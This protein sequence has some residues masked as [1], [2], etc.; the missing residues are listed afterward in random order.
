[1]IEDFFLQ[2]FG[3]DFDMQKIGVLEGIIYESETYFK[4]SK[5]GAYSSMYCKMAWNE[6][7][8]TNDADMLVFDILYRIDVENG[9]DTTKILDSTCFNGAFGAVKVTI[10]SL[11]EGNLSYNLSVCVYFHTELYA[12][13][14]NKQPFPL[15]NP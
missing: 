9:A 11:Q 13:K 10:T 5:I 2:Y 12:N 6:E 7:S 15:G 4:E 8:L 1:M 3:S 14:V